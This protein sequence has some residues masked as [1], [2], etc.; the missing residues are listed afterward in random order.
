MPAP[1]VSARADAVR[2]FNRFYTR[3]IGVLR[4]GF[5][6]SPFS[7]AEGR[8]LY[9]LAQR[10]DA[11]SS[12]LARALDLDAGYLSRILRSFE[13]QQLIRRKV[14]PADRRRS[15]LAL[16]AKGRKEFRLLD[17][18]AAEDVRA[19]LSRIPESGQ[20]QLIQA[21]STIEHTLGGAPRR[22]PYIL[23]P[24]RSGDM[25]WVVHRHGILYAQE[26]GWNEE[27]EA[28]VA[29][30]VAEFI[31]N[32]DPRRERCW[33]AER[34]GIPLGSVFL[35]KDSETVAKL[36]LLL[37]EPEARGLGLGR[38]LVSECIHFARTAGYQ[39]VTLW[40]NDVLVAA[41][42]IYEQAGFRL[43]EENRHHSFGKDL[44]GQNWTLDLISPASG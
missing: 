36:R 34:D 3:Q 26:Y 1:T 28:L 31:E 5:L 22:E 38:R 21:M 12:E 35:V 30:I 32:F 13:Q 39:S 42:G 37:V 24:H 44:V 41:R 9:E 14:S 6:N 7:L 16:T 17:A 29:R 33:I 11:G 2:R 27:M 8:V 40:T 43:V 23:R 25:G 15:L 20:Q 10:E 18:R 4:E 19:M